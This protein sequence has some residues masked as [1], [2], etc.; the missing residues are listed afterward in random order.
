MGQDKLNTLNPLAILDTRATD[1]NKEIFKVDIYEYVKCR[2][3]L[4]ANLDSAI[5]PSCSS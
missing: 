5:P 3:R 1:V 2:N 4:R